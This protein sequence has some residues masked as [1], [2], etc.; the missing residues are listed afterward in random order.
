MKIP[1]SLLQSSLKVL[2]LLV[3]LRTKEA[4]QSKIIAPFVE[5][6]QQ[7]NIMVLIRAMDARVS[8]DD[9][10]ERTILISAEES[11]TAQSKEQIEIPVGIAD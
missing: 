11:A 6:G 5:I 4:F 3:P 1:S 8:S 2:G 9:L 7:E 10:S